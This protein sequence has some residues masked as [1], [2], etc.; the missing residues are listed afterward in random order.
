MLYYFLIQNF[1][2][3]SESKPLFGSEVFG[4]S[5][6]IKTP[7]TNLFGGNT[8]GENK[9]ST[10]FSFKLP[11]STTVTPI[12]SEVTSSSLSPS[13]GSGTITS[14][15]IT[16]D[17]KNQTTATPVFGSSSGMSF[18]DLAKTTTPN[19]ASGAFESPG[20]LSFASLAQT[21]TNGS[22]AFSKPPTTG[23]FIGLSNKD[24]FSNLMAP[25]PPV[26]GTSQNAT[27]EENDN[28]ND[29][30]DPNHEHDPHF[31][32]I[33]EL[34]DEIQVSTGEEN[35]EKLFGDRAKLYRYDSD[36][37]EVCLTFQSILIFCLQKKN[38]N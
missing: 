26:N 5:N 10:G 34:P 9:V 18:A 27:K 8:N 36:N 11:P 6:V 24:T 16:E 19:N 23:G 2:E 28:E 4:N 15:P 30:V 37:K 38:N 25:K 17:S 35:E 22:P 33:I 32:P 20:G 14:T 21:T 3:K 12:L 29:D 13:A 7:S 31:E 1:T